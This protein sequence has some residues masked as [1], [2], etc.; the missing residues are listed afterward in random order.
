MHEVKS[1]VRI[2]AILL[3]PMVFFSLLVIHHLPVNQDEFLPY[4]PLSILTKHYESQSSMSGGYSRIMFGYSI[5]VLSYPY[6][7]A[8]KAW[9]YYFSHLPVTIPAIRLFHG[10]LCCLLVILVAFLA[11][12]LT[13]NSKMAFLYCLLFLV[14][15]TALLVHAITDEGPILLALIFGSI[16][17]LLMW[18]NQVV[19]KRKIAAITAITFFGVWDRINFIWF[20]VSGCIAAALAIVALNKRQ[21]FFYFTCAVFATI[22]GAVLAF[23]FVP[24]YFSCLI[25]GFRDSIPFSDWRVLWQHFVMLSNTSDPFTAFHRYVDVSQ[26]SFSLLYT[27]YRLSLLI[28]YLL[29]GCFTIYLSFFRKKDITVIFP[30]LFFAVT[31]VIILALMIV[32]T[33]ESWAYHHIALLKPFIYVA[34]S[35]VLGYSIQTAHSVTRR[36]VTSSV[37]GLIAF[38]TVVGF[39]G[40][41]AVFHAPNIGGY[42]DVSWNAMDAARYACDHNVGHVYALDWGA[43]YPGVTMSRPGQRWEMSTALTE[44]ALR[45]LPASA[46]GLDFS[47]LFRVNGEHGWLAARTLNEDIRV[48]DKQTFSNYTGEIWTYLVLNTVRTTE[49]QAATNVEFSTLNM[50]SNILCNGDFAR[51]ITAWEYEEYE[52]V[53]YCAASTICP[54]SGIH[55]SAAI[56][57]NHHKMADSRV[58]QQVSFEAGCEYEVAGYIRTEGVPRASKGAHLC[59]MDAPIESS[60]LNGDTDWQ[61]VTFFVWNRTSEK[62]DLRLAARLGTYG[63]MNRGKAYFD[64]ITVRRTNRE[65]RTI[66]VYI[67]SDK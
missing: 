31:A 12:K 3:V 37:I 30:G 47:V 34:I 24:N 39:I 52:S 46:K 13:S 38:Y 4:F 40:L 1:A 18:P 66:P 51:G 7:G 22:L 2:F 29:V 54:T 48:I 15:D 8:V 50:T 53:S 43:F 28:A 5:P 19:T 60:A 11:Y 32:K 9:L 58:I 57:L 36:I 44:T 6:I 17:L 42:Y 14:T 21:S 56:A 61:Q 16:Y 35:I 25:K 45:K 10:V 20:L 26:A 65:D 62:K 23:L 49:L 59:I 67:L 27:V 63:A 33:R 64:N 41:N 55:H